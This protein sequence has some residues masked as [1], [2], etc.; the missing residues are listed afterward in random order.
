VTV[1]PDTQLSYSMYPDAEQLVFCIGHELA[2]LRILF[3]GEALD[4]FIFA[5]IAARNDLMSEARKHFGFPDAPIDLF[6]AE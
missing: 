1:K 2:D 3:H 5:L 6:P 4:R